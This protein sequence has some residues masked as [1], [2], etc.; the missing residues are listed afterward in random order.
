[1]SRSGSN[2]QSNP[3]PPLDQIQS[4]IMYPQ[5]LQ[6]CHDKLWAYKLGRFEPTHVYYHLI[7]RGLLTTH[8]MED[9]L[10]SIDGNKE[11]RKAAG[12][13]ATELTKE[14][15]AYERALVKKRKRADEQQAEAQKRTK[16][17]DDPLVM[18]QNHKAITY[19]PISEEDRKKVF[20]AND[21]LLLVCMADQGRRVDEMESPFLWEGGSTDPTYFPIGTPVPSVL[22]TFAQIR[23]Y[24]TDVVAP[25]LFHTTDMKW[26]NDV[27]ELSVVGHGMVV[28]KMLCHP[29]SPRLM[30]DQSS[31]KWCVWTGQVWAQETADYHVGLV[32]KSLHFVYKRR[33]AFLQHKLKEMEV[34]KAVFMAMS[35]NFKGGVDHQTDG[36]YTEMWD[37]MESEAASIRKQ[38]AYFDGEMTKVCDGVIAPRICG[39]LNKSAV[40]AGLYK[41]DETATTVWDT[42]PAL[43]SDGKGVLYWGTGCSVKRGDGYVRTIHRA[44]HPSDFCLVSLK[45]GVHWNSA[46]DPY[47]RDGSWTEDECGH[48]CPTWVRFL[49]E[50]LGQKE[51][52]KRREA[53]V[54]DNESEEQ[55]VARIDQE[56]N[57]LQEILGANMSY[58]VKWQMIFVMFNKQ[59]RNGK[60]VTADTLEHMAGDIVSSIAKACL[61]CDAK[62]GFGSADN[63]HESH[64]LTVKEPHL[65]IVSESSAHRVWN[66]EPAKG[67]SGDDMVKARGAHAKKS[68]YFKPKAT[69]MLL[70]NDPPTF[71]YGIDDALVG[72]LRMLLLG[73]RFL[74]KSE[75]SNRH[76]SLTSTCATNRSKK[77]CGRS[78]PASSPGFG[79]GGRSSTSVAAFSSRPRWNATSKTTSTAATSP[80]CLSRTA[81]RTTR[82]WTTSAPSPLS[83]SPRSSRRGA[84]SVASTAPP[85]SVP[86]C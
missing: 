57:A 70:C 11:K 84:R 80:P 24:I 19:P 74:T 26:W 53:G 30:Y 3:M 50:I 73:Q 63:A 22:M 55:M 85:T 36:F 7:T 28:Q 29:Q 42:N 78:F 40:E 20:D 37:K 21:D 54:W 76:P 41:T 65:G 16:S 51:L 86:R 79:V 58:E 35:A 9:V 44:G 15:K 39:A 43:L 10:T 33:V 13:S 8:E 6:T 71:P 46:Y 2:S 61:I 59:G 23:A 12:A 25:W 4:Q 14:C 75:L 34:R 66:T 31:K 47:V 38:L 49:R 48:P 5:R 56:F 17:G 62:R 64:L 1:M 69:M 32:A 60:G 83:G 77:S 81:A 67:I 18:L 72:R 82:R 52:E 45:P 68:E 27:V